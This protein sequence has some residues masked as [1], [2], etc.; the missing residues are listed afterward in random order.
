MAEFKVRKIEGRLAYAWAVEW[1]G[2]DGRVVAY[3]DNKIEAGVIARLLNTSDTAPVW[4]K[5]A[6]VGLAVKE[7]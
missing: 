7:A 4:Y 2:C 1:S 5:R 3:C 6:S